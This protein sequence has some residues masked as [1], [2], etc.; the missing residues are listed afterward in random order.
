[1]IFEFEDRFLDNISTRRV[2]D[3]KLIRVEASSQLVFPDGTNKGVRSLCLVRWAK[4][5]PA[6][7]L[8]QLMRHSSI[9]TTMSFYVNIT[10]KD[11]MSE[12]RRHVQKNSPEKVNGE[13]NEH[14]WNENR[15]LSFSPNPLFLLAF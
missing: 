5:V 15:G 6:S 3:D 13:V 11:T 14:S 4:I 8:Q 10:A 7:L 1:L 2:Q 12:I 9:E